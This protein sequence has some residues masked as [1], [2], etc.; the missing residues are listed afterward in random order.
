LNLVRDED[1]LRRLGRVL[2]ASDRIRFLSPTLHQEMFDEL[3]WP[4]DADPDLGID[5]HTLGLSDADLAKLE[6]AGRSDV[7]SHVARWRGGQALGDT[8]FDRVVGSSA[9]AVISTGGD[10]PA[11]FV[12]GGAA[13][14]RFWMV[15]N[16]L[17]LGVY[18]MSPIFLYARRQSDLLG[19]APE[20][21]SDLVTLKRDMDDIIGLDFDQVPVLV[22][23]LAHR[24]GTA[25]RSRRRALTE[26]LVPAGAL[27]ND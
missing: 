24:P 18:P 26:M 11:D 7:M 19:L 14:E 20:H 23:R 9:M 22:L 4:G 2:A 12:R 27:T 13:V 25:P 16:S 17:G 5:V 6:V 21:S 1:G 10:R 8:T 15:A 3:R